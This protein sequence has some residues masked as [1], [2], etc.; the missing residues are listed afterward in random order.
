MLT[1]DTRELHI[2]LDEPA[3]IDFTAGQYVQ[4]R[5]PTPEGPV[6]RAYS[7]SSSP[8]SRGRIEMVVRLVPG[9]VGST[10][11][12]RLLVGEPIEFTGPF[13]DYAFDAATELVCVGGG[14]GL[15]PIRSIAD[16]LCRR[17]PDATCW[18]FLGVRTPADVFYRQA[19]ERLASQHANVRLFYALSEPR[20]GEAWDGPVGMIDRVVAAELTDGASRQAFLCG[21]AAMIEAAR[22]V[23]REKGVP[24]E[25]IFFEDFLPS[26]A[27]DQ[28]PSALFE[29]H[30]HATAAPP[31]G[32]RR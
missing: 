2:R 27:P 23:L 6:E 17:N 12:H 18:L 1:H 11:L 16:D 3:E 22:A 13:G 8:S 7:I 29:E 15:A 31:K 21:P 28:I 26:V 25:R 10:Y 19:F 30:L 9:G 24:D 14:C 5:V 32:G 4:V 20:H